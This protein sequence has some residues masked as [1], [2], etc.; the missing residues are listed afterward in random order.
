MI[1][2]LLACAGVKMKL[3]FNEKRTMRRIDLK[4]ETEGLDFRI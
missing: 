4:G 3:S 2:K 1:S